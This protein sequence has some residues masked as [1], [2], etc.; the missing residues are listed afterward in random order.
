MPA[1][2]RNAILAVLN[3][4]FDDAIPAPRMAMADSAIVNGGDRP[5]RRHR[6]AV[7]WPPAVAAIDK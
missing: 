3:A 2:E 4:D 7:R 6:R 5:T 1:R